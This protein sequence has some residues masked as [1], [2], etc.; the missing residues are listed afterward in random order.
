M[1]MQACMSHMV[2]LNKAADT[3]EGKESLEPLLFIKEKYSQDCWCN[4]SHVAIPQ[5][6]ELQSGSVA[7]GSSCA[8]V[9]DEGAACH[10][11]AEAMES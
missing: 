7:G 5:N 10:S 4:A 8:A 1:D 9:A 2:C 11:M 3:A 6:A